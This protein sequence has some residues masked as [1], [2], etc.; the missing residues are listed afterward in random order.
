MTNGTRMI[1]MVGSVSIFSA[2][3]ISLAMGGGFAP[4]VFPPNE[5]IEIKLVPVELPRAVAEDLEPRPSPRPEIPEAF[6]TPDQTP[7]IA[8]QGADGVWRFRE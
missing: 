2:L 1:V 7:S 3:I 4:A 5:S 6:R 8:Y